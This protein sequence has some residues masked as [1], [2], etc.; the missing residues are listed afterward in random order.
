M[1]DTKLSRNLKVVRSV[2]GLNQFQFSDLMGVPRTTYA[3]HEQGNSE[4]SLSF[5]ERLIEVTG[6]PL[7][8][9]TKADL[10][11]IPADE[12]RQ[13]IMVTSSKLLAKQSPS[14]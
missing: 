14:L 2:M 5:M 7:E 3:H 10:S 4:P 12:L 8:A 13:Q 9:F 6:K 1:S 11:E